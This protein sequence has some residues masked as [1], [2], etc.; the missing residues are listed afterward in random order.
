M[1]Y[2]IA[3]V[4]G[5]MLAAVVNATSRVSEPP[6]YHEA[7][8]FVGFVASIAWIYALAA[9]MI[10]VLQ[11]LGALVGLSDTILGLT[12]LAFA[13]SVGDLVANLAM[14]RAGMPA[15]AAAACIGGPLLNLLLGSGLATL[16]GNWLVASPY[17]FEMNL[18]LYACLVFQVFTLVAMVSIA[19]SHKWEVGRNF[20]I[21]LILIYVFFMVTCLG[22]E[23]WGGQKML[24]SD[25]A[26]RLRNGQDIA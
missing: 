8:A 17:P 7:V 26:K 3:L 11:A 24:N 4:L 21:G 12:V 9:E 5:L 16:L 23:V 13:N 14:A 2:A 6:P 10:H 1:A 25:I 20:G 18:Q 22:L 15:M 19:W